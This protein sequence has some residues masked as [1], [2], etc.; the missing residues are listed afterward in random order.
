M[1]DFCDRVDLDE[2]L[3]SLILDDFL[4]T[5]FT[6]LFD[7]CGAIGM[8]F[9]AALELR[10]MALAPTRLPPTSLGRFAPSLPS[11]SGPPLLFCG[12]AQTCA[13]SPPR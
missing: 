2:I 11:P 1:I 3:L 12:R 13:Y 6:L 8:D 9:A 10:P 5:F 7:L 4:F